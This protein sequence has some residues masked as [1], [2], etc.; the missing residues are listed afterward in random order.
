M[1]LTREG[2]RRIR[3]MSLR[4]KEVLERLHSAGDAIEFG[5]GDLGEDNFKVIAEGLQ[6]NRTL[7]NLSSQE[8]ATRAA[9]CWLRAS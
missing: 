8:S 5:Y 7:K 9:R 2:A 6:T 4:R 1:V 3:E